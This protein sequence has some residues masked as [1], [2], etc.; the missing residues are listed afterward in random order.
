MP[1]PPY[2]ASVLI[3]KENQDGFAVE[4]FHWDDLS[5]GDPVPPRG[6]IIPALTAGTF[7][8]AGGLAFHKLRNATTR[9]DLISKFTAYVNAKF[10]DTQ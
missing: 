8:Q 3:I 7:G 9:A 4:I 5:E 10:P 2:S 6:N 1:N